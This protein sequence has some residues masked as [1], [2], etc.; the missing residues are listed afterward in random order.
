MIE[1]QNVSCDLG[2]RRVL[3]GID[4]VCNT[5]EIIGLVGASG[6]GKSVLLKLI[7]GKI[8]HFEGDVRINDRPYASYGEKEFH[9]VTSYLDERPENLDEAVADFLLLSRIPYKRFLNPFTDYDL[10]AVE[11]AM[12]VFDLEPLRDEPLAALSGD[13]FSRVLLAFAFARGSRVMLLD[14]P[15]KEL[16]VRSTVLLQKAIAR[17]V[18]NGDTIVIIASNDLNFIAQ[19]ADRV[20]V[21]DEGRVALAGT[22]DSIDADLIKQY[23]G[24]DVFVSRNVYNGRPNVHFFP[25]S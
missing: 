19:T 2:R 6:S 23:F 7:A 12:A 8:S 9:R 22:H 21:L 13:Q 16:D 24:V 3:D 5:G 4:L 14:N 17:Y 18:L 11:Q 1:L 25:E 10:Q 15:T 20:I